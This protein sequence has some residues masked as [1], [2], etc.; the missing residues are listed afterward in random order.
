MLGVTAENR[1]WMR[2]RSEFAEAMKAAPDN[3]F[4]N[5]GLNFRAQR[6]V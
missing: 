6:F 1:D 5:L 2:A 4:Y 3:V